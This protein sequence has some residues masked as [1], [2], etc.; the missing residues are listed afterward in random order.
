MWISY[1]DSEVSCF[2]P[3]C[4]Q[5]LN[6]ALRMMH[7][8]GQYNVL[9]HQHTGALEM[10]YVIQ[11]TTTGNYLCVIEVKRTPSD[12]HSARYQFQA[13]SY[14][15]MNAN[16]SEKPFYILTNLECAFCFRYDSSR[17]RV[18]QQMLKPGLIHIGSFEEDEQEDFTNKLAVFFQGRLKDYINDSYDYLITLNEFA[19]HMELIKENPK[20]WKSHLAVL[21]Y[22]YI[23][24]VFSF[25]NRNEL[26]DIRLFGNNVKNICSEAARVNFKD[27][28]NYSEDFFENAVNIDNIALADLFNFGRQNVSGDSVAGVLHS[29]VSAGHEHEGEVPTDLEL[30]RIVTELAKYSSG[31]LETVDVVCDPAAG[32]GNLISAAIPTYNLI[33]T[34]IKV[35]DINSKLIELLSLRIGL[36]YA[37]T[38][39]VIASQ[40]S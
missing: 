14:V 28:F 33:P 16:Q 36:T 38:V 23:R 39:Q 11:N 40:W 8:D 10:D 35:N 24:G 15:Q 19:I 17:P 13:M 4:E 26:R 2:H 7:L 3:I 25:I 18:F 1:S 30:A 34:Q 5:A 29:I 22:E 31:E 9:H 12:V 32:S 37:S 27:I 21:L 6:K 20:S